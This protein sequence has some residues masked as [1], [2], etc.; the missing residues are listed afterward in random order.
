MNDA[1]T[2][3]HGNKMT[4]GD[5]PNRRIIKIVHNTEKSPEELR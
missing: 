2:R 3:E 1:S 5:H 4:C